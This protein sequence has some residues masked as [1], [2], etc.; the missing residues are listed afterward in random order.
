[1][2]NLFKSIIISALVVIIGAIF[3]EFDLQKIGLALILLG[4]W[5]FLSSP[6]IADE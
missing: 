5:G 3:L 2:N 6:M 1:M 4:V